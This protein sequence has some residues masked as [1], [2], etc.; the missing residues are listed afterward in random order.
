MV[1]EKIERAGSGCP[2]TAFMRLGLHSLW[3]TLLYSI[4]VL[5]SP[6]WAQPESTA[7]THEPLDAPAEVS[8]G[9]YLPDS[10]NI[11]T[12]Q[13]TPYLAG[14]DGRVPLH[15]L[16]DNTTSQDL[17]PILSLLLNKTSTTTCTTVHIV[18]LSQDSR[19]A[20]SCSNGSTPEVVADCVEARIRD[21]LPPACL[22]SFDVFVP[23]TNA[24]HGAWRQFNAMFQRNTGRAYLSLQYQDDTYIGG[25]NFDGALY[26][27]GVIDA[28]ASLKSLLYTLQ[29]RFDNPNV[30][31][32]GHSKGSH[33]VA[34]VAD[35]PAYNGMQFFAFA[36]AGRTALDISARDDIKAGRLGSP[37]FI[38]KLSDNLVGITWQNDEVKFYKGS[39]YS[40]LLMPE[41]WGFPGYIWQ[42]TI[43][44]TLPPFF[45]IDHHNNYGG[46][47]TDGL[48]GNIW[49]MG[50]GTTSNKYPYCATGNK[51][52][53]SQQQEC[54]KKDVEYLPYFW[55]NAECRDKAFEIMDTGVPGTTKYYIGYS[56]P[57]AAGCTD[58]ARTVQ[59][60]YRLEYNLNLADQ[61]DC[62]YDM[63]LQFEGINSSG[64]PYTRDSG[65]SIRVS[66]T[67]DTGWTSRTGTVKLPYHMQIY[68]KA[69]MTDV[70]S[71]SI[72]TD[73]GHLIAASEGYIKKLE[74]TFTHPITEIRT[75]RTLIG[76]KEGSD[77]PLINL[78]RKNN[79]AWWNWNDPNDTR[80]SWDLFYAPLNGGVLM[81]KGDTDENRKGHF[82][83]WLHLVD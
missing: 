1:L 55:G 3:I 64:L 70:S 80:D 83:K 17:V 10:S 82:Y 51:Y 65:G 62:R 67:R 33:A 16:K 66:S 35:E 79:V 38:H 18:N 29:T 24:E 11:I 5:A 56:G 21:R 53:W 43:G 72:L 47:Y 9:V 25:T 69:S 27:Q 6:C 32:F 59:A 41:K 40:G 14:E 57:R 36:Q 54:I 68:L 63:Q 26:D 76:L 45:R 60:S 8:P 42:S 13:D 74:V 44:G 4:L 58:N 81:I 78:D 77:Y 61:D 34:L 28:R 7:Q 37:G 49:Q 52:V 39:G 22:G 23:G 20:D 46:R 73:C 75:K 30:R 48:P 2:G 31:V 71:S 50:Q 12:H 19:T 15:S